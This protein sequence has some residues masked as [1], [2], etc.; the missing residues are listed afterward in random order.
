M[1]GAK[2]LEGARRRTPFGITQSLTDAYI[3][4]SGLGPEAADPGT[5]A[6]AVLTTPLERRPA[7]RRRY[8][9]LAGPVGIRERWAG[10]DF[11]DFRGRPM[12]APNAP[13][14]T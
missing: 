12:A 2:L 7:L 11:R 8:G 5:A 3:R 9:G 10:T 1:I 6:G 4:D 14:P 13:T